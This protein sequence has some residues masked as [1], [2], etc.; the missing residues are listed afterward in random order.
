LQ[1]L[2]GSGNGQ[3]VILNP[4]AGLVTVR[5]ACRMTSRRSRIS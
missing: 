5:A 4:Q 1:H 2:I 3:A